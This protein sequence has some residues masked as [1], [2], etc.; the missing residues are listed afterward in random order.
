MLRKNDQTTLCDQSDVVEDEVFTNLVDAVVED[1][2]RLANLENDAFDNYVMRVQS[3][4]HVDVPLF[5]SRFTNGYHTL[6]EQIKYE[7][8]S[9]ESKKPEDKT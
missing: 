8:S 5:R 2:N 6:L 9:H 7:K 1:A 3:K 4:L